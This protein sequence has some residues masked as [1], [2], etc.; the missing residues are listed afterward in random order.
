MYGVRAKGA[1]T[2]YGVHQPFYARTNPGIKF[3]KPPAQGYAP[4]GVSWLALQNNSKGS[5]T[6]CI[7][8][9]MRTPA[10]CCVPASGGPYG[11]EG[12]RRRVLVRIPSGYAGPTEG[13]VPG[14]GEMSLIRQTWLDQLD[15]DIDRQIAEARQSAIK[16]AICRRVRSQSSPGSIWATTRLSVRSVMRTRRSSVLGR[17]AFAYGQASS[18]IRTLG[19]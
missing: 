17:Q 5:R 19:Q 4:G 18:T 1:L 12:R 9:V 3:Y 15:A 14:G 16:E 13:N 2:K 6:R 7:S 11:G 10:R 8:P